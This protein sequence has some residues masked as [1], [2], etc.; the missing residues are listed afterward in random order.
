M[1]VKKGVTAT[2]NIIN[3]AKE[4]SLYNNGMKPFVFSTKQYEETECGWIRDGTEISYYRNGKTLQSSNQPKDYDFD[5]SYLGEKPTK[6]FRQLSTLTFQ[7]TFNY[8]NDIVFFSHFVPYTYSDHVNMLDQISVVPNAVNFLRIDNLC[9]TLCNN[10]CH[11]ITIT[12]KIQTYWPFK[13]EKEVLKKCDHFFKKWKQIKLDKEEL[14]KQAQNGG[15]LKCKKKEKTKGKKPFRNDLQST[16]AQYDEFYNRL[17]LD[18][19]NPALKQ[20]KK[21]HRLK[22]CI[23]LTSRVHPG[24]SN[25]SFMSNGLIKYLISDTPEAI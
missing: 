22:K 23:F 3:L 12:D 9:N 11:I 21:D 25:A 6:R 18:K 4:D 1:N 19:K 2:F 24:E 5:N 16:I 8:D 17:Y 7:Y 20:H 10:P 15:S 13:H 14:E